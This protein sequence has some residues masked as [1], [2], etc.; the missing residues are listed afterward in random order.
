MSKDTRNVAIILASGSGSRFRSETPKQ[1]LKLA[2]KTVLEHTLDVFEQHR[3]ID[4]IVLVINPAYRLLTEELVNKAGYRK[5]RKIVDGGAT[6]QES[7][8]SGIRA[9]DGDEHKV[10]VHDGVRPLINKGII[11]R[12]LDALDTNIAVDT[13]IP[14]PDTIIEVDADD[15]IVDIPRRANLRLGQTPQG[16]RAGVLRH[17][18]DLAEKDPN[19]EVTDD[20]GLIL[21]YDLG[22]IAVVPGDVNNIKITY[23]SD[24]YLADRLFQMRSSV[25]EPASALEILEGRVLVVFGGS[26]GIGQRIAELATEKGAQVVSVSRS[27]GVDVAD[28]QAVRECLSRTRQKLGHIDMVANSAGILR[29]GLLDGQDYDDIDMQIDA[30]LRGSIVVAKESFPFLKEGGGS[31]ALFTSSSYT[32]GRARSAVYSATKAAIVNLMQGLAQEYLPFGVRINAINPERTHTPMRTENFGNEPKEQLLDADTV[33]RTTLY[34]LTSS[35]TG[36]VIDVRL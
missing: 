2:G 18:H 32:R 1:F 34:A 10:L 36:E 3:D 7:T 5:V 13:G 8:A 25:A 17:A 14:S 15:H 12:C 27:D 9:V 4:D 29:V 35:H 6:R 16:F 33:A 21:K 20:C 30:N 28:A 19:L 26:R 31:L 23:P 11:D 24:I 22:A